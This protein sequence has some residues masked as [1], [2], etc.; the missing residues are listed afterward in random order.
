MRKLFIIFATA[1]LLCVGCNNRYDDTDVWN[2]IDSI[3]QRLSAMEI[4]MNAY[5]NKLLIQSVEIL[6][7]GYV[8][9][10]SDGS[11]ATILNGKNGQDGDTYI[12]DIKVGEES[13]TFSLTDGQNFTMQF[14][15]A[16][17]IEFGAEDMLAMIAGQQREICYSITSPND[18]IEIEVLSSADIKAS[19]NWLE[20]NKKEGNICIMPI[21]EPDAIYSKVVVIVSNGSKVIM[22]RFR[23]SDSGIDVYDNSEKK[24]ESEGG[25]LELEFISS[26][27]YEVIIPDEASEW[28]SYGSNETRSELSRQSISLNLAKNPGYAREAFVTVR[29]PYDES[30]CVDFHIRQKP[31]RE[32]VQK[33]DRETL[34]DLYNSLGGDSS[35]WWWSNWCTDAPLEEWY[36]VV[37]DEMSGRVVELCLTECEGAVPPSVGNLTELEKMVFQHCIITSLP[38][39]IGL[40]KALE[41]LEIY[42]IYNNNRSLKSLP[43][44]IGNM[45]ALRHLDLCNNNI[46]SLPSSMSELKNLEYIDLSFNTPLSGNVLDILTELK[47]LKHINLYYDHNITGTLESITNLTNLEYFDVGLT[48][49]SGSIPADIGKL[50]NLQEFSVMDTQVS[51]PLPSSMS[52]LR[53]VRG[54]GFSGTK[55]SG[56]L[57]EWLGELDNL[58][59]LLLEFT[60][61]SGEIPKSLANLKKLKSLSLIGTNI[62]GKIPVGFGNIPTLEILYLADCKLTGGIP[63]DIGNIENLWLF[64]NKLSGD[65]PDGII[66]SK[67][68]R[69]N[70]GLIAVGNDF[71]LAGLTF[72]G[73]DFT[74]DV[75]I[76]G[77]RKYNIADEYAK[78]KYTILF[79]WHVNCVYLASTVALLKRI[80]NKYNTSGLKV[81]GRTYMEQSSKDAIK[82]LSMPWETYYSQ[83]LD[84]PAYIA[85]TIT[86]IDNSGMV[87]FSDVIQNRN[88]LEAFMDARYAED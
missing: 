33:G 61:V 66:N 10:F 17:S 24:V 41:Y 83:Q 30:L 12:A 37:V 70:W 21:S 60:D 55:I 62:H 28:I 14:Y 52:L 44:E 75:E 64:N 25:E 81:I 39:E 50:S 18:D 29:C 5:K 9:I 65:I 46:A 48:K 76:L 67:K 57:P 8:I 19:I 31:D 43:Q 36:G 32:F 80:H 13:V 2:S 42:G 26:V 85:P 38:A 79:Q 51:G 74:M 63:E 84:Y 58:E 71:N 7:N 3:E 82:N 69:N 86:V 16:L 15:N 34:T 45:E 54:L 73:P 22:R 11:K 49:I 23:F 77:D 35:K 56:T 40:L 47:K 68:W 78:N 20:E 1:T 87:I 72:P 53:N 59:N 88:D 6:E 4:V 27:E